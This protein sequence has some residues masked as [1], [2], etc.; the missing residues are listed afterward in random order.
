MQ[1]WGR[2]KPVANEKRGE[3]S[4]GIGLKGGALTG[5]Q[6]LEIIRI[7]GKVVLNLQT[8]TSQQVEETFIWKTCVG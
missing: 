7:V 5:K 6:G 2:I 8:H 1:L 3:D 4:E